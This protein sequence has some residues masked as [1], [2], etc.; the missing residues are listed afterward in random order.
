MFGALEAHFLEVT[1]AWLL[2]GKDL[3]TNAAELD[4]RRKLLKAF[5]AHKA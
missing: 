5:W 4:Q 2:I 3:P 1:F